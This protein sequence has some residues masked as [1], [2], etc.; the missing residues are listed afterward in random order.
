[1][2]LL[3]VPSGKLGGA[4]NLIWMMARELGL[5]GEATTIIVLSRVPEARWRDLPPTCRLIEMGGRS[6]SLGMLRAINLIWRVCQRHR[7]RRVFSSH[8]H[9]NSYLSTL[10][11][12]GVLRCDTLVSRES[13]QIAQRFKGPRLWIAFL[14]YA[15][16]YGEQ[17]RVVCQTG[18]MLDS[19][20]RFVPNSA[21]W[22][23]VVEPNPVDVQLARSRS[24]EPG[25]YSIGP[26]LPA[27]VALG[28]MI[29]EK[30][31]PTL[32]RAFAIHLDQHPS[33][34]LIIVG[35]GPQRA[36]LAELAARLGIADRVQMP[37]HV[38]NPHRAL[39]E[40]HICVVPSL[41]E[42][43]PNTLLEMM[44]H[45]DR[46]VSTLCASDIEKIPGLH[47][48]V[49]GDPLALSRAMHRAEL[50]ASSHARRLLD[51]ELESRS[52][53]AYMERIFNPVGSP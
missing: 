50:A 11:R 37:G 52:P 46:I 42:G 10:R 44:V 7:I 36:E 29:P 23:I 9:I 16:G 17:D 45:C 21:G 43:F 39:S 25:C 13:T 14:Q 2:N 1:M 41:R 48:C 3:L 51:T 27:I 32:L 8:T 34:R 12:I 22:N 18:G 26:G 30:G 15:L 33:R 5:L 4:E 24:G 40:A 35:E 47:T 49:T 19:L 38:P 6:E 31:F 28:R 53:R 20:R